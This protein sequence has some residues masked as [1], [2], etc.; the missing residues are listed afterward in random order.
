LRIGFGGWFGGGKED[1]EDDS[2]DKEK[3]GGGADIAASS[4]ANAASLKKSLVGGVAGIMDSMQ[5]FKKTQRVA[6]L[7]SSLLQDLGSM[8]VE[9]SA[10]DGKVRVSFD[11]Q[12]RPVRVD[13]DESYFDSVESASDL[14]DAVTAAMR[15]AHSKSSERQAERVT[16]F[17]NNDL[18]LPAPPP[19]SS[20]QQ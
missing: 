12:Q 1:G 7:T 6:K 14:A 3:S 13:I 19:S 4:V 18:G 11:C 20:Q 2:D 17:L 9:G 10:A 15:I 16:K 5:N 8:T